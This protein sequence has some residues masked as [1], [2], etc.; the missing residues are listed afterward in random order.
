MTG[1]TKSSISQYV[2]GK[3][4]PKQKALYA[5]AKALNVSEA[6]LMG[7]SVPRERII[8]NYPDNIYKIETKNSHSWE[9]L[10]VDNLFMLKNNLKVILKPVQI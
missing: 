10:L 8:T 9:Q 1:I 2:S 6:W 3:F 4:E 7:Y 5:L